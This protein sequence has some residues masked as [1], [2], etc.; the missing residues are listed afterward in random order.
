MPAGIEVAV[1]EMTFMLKRTLKSEKVGKKRSSKVVGTASPVVHSSQ[2]EV[3][4]KY[5]RSSYPSRH[6]SNNSFIHS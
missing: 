1:I 4:T 5:T 2:A 6:S 3:K